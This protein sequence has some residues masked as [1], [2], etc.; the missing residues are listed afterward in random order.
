MSTVKL[1][2]NNNQSKL[3]MDLVRTYLHEIGQVPLLE[4][5]EE[6]TYGQQVQRYMLLLAEKETL[7]QQRGQS[8]SQSE[9]AD[10]VGLSETEL[11]RLLRQGQLAKNKMIQANLRLVVSV[12]KKYLRRKVEF[13]DLIQEGSLG[14]ERAV[15]KFDPSKGYK[16]S[17]YAY[18][19]I[20]Q[21]ITRAISQQ[22]R[23]I[24]LPIHITEKLNQIKKA[25]RELAQKL[26]RSA[27]PSDVAFE[28]GMESAK[29]REYL[30]MARVPLSLDVRIGDEQNTELS[31]MIQD[32]SADPFDY[33]TTESMR[34][35]VRKM[36]KDLN[37]KERE[38][39]SLRFGL[40]DGTEWSLASI[41][42]KL[43]I[44]RE[45]VRQLQNRALGHLR[46][47]PPLALWD[48]LA[49]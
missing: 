35:D 8:I 40:K 6:I 26:G 46:S 15:E 12:A 19:W 22:S 37:P 23:T 2:E 48:Y 29:V 10:A 28:L 18:W 38:V 41:G 21:A 39:L 14:L 3:S 24:R 36:L 30:K 47:K 44:S 11:K 27:T 33:T 13:L 20:R 9:W 34:Q 49:S 42:Q 45:R 7:E 32:D 31:E 43:N 16:F 5:S 4:R 1:S 17:T 25:Q